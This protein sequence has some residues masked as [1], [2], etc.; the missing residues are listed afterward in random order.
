MTDYSMYLSPARTWPREPEP[1]A[2]TVPMPQNSDQAAA[3]VLLGVAWLREHAPERLTSEAAHVSNMVAQHARKDVWYW[4]ND[5]HDHL[6]S[7]VNSLPVVIRAD[8]LRGLVEAAKTTVSVDYGT[9]K[10]VMDV[11]EAT[12]GARRA[13]LIEM[14]WTPPGEAEVDAAILDWMERQHTLHRRVEM[15]YVVDGYEVALMHDDE[16][17]PLGAKAPTLREA[18]QETMRVHPAPPRQ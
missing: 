10:T 11:A 9:Q 13:K 6:E 14:G 7:M 5:G 1:S 16:P 3:M 18:L 4:Q 12:E 15:L 2:D 8:H 17:H